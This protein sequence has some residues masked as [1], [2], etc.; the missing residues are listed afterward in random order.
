[1]SSF[2]FKVKEMIDNPTANQ[3]LIWTTASPVW[4][5]EA[6]G[7][8]DK[9][10]R[11]NEDGE[12]EGDDWAYTGEYMFL[13]SFEDRENVQ[14]GEGITPRRIKR[15]VEF[16]DSKGTARLLDLVQKGRENLALFQE[17]QKVN[18]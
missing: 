1:M 12:E 16:V 6:L 7:S 14:E 11:K 17:N 15:I 10:Q 4:L 18:V 13:L 2:P 5:P 9:G 8:V 3:V